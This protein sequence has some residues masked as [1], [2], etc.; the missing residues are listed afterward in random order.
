M[1][2]KSRRSFL[3]KVG[4]TS[5]IG[6]GVFNTFGEVFQ[7]ALTKQNLASS[8]SDLKIT[9]ITSAY[10]TPDQRKMFVKIETN[11]GITG[12]G[13]GVDAVGGTH[14]LVKQLGA[15]L[16]GKSPL[17]VN[18]LF[19]DLRRIAPLSP[20]TGSQAGIFIAVLSAIDI[21][22]WDVAGKA[23]ALPV[24]QLLGGKFR[25]AVHMYTHPVDNSGTPENIAAS[26]LAAKNA[27]Y[28]AVKFW[29]DIASFEND[30][31]KQDVYNP[32][33]N[34][35]EIDRIV[36]TVAAVRQ[37]I[38]PAMAMM[39][40]MHTRFDLPTAIR[41]VKAFELFDPTWIEE[42]VPPENMDALREVTQSS[43]TPICVGE[44]LYMVHQF[45]QLLDRK[46]A[47][48]IMPDVQKCGGIGE[49]QRIANLAYA[50][51]VPFAPH[52]VGT[53]FAMMASAH[54]CASIPNFF[55]LESNQKTV[56]DWE[57]IVADPPAIKNSFL[58]V[59]DK[60][61]IGL[62]IVEDGLRK[63]ATAGMPFFE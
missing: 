18:R 52:M 2:A 29:V 28:D 6:A 40:E 48:I 57:G 35:K 15:K 30:P 34:N 55:M 20:F 11:Q 38:G 54:V 3:K 51:Y 9:K 21:A 25:D 47:D 16:V 36:K 33:A 49:A 31:N 62:E 39:V 61:G 12:Y 60:P 41:L 8:P 44:N 46:A 7:Q 5:A 32:T 1:T 23:L 4:L 26:C 10:F 45:Q 19:E 42:P 43:S 37:A 53:P 56:S 22:L 63:Y 24:Y 14:Y 13:E 58:K 59:S 17:N 27:G 50:H